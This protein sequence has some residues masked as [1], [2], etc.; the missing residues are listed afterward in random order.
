MV[1]EIAHLVCLSEGPIMSSRR[2]RPPRQVWLAL[3]TMILERDGFTCQ[4]CG[5]WRDL[6]IHH[7]RTRE[8]GGPDSPENLITL[9]RDCHTRLHQPRGVRVATVDTGDS[10]ARSAP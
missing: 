10:P 9:C 3:R 7:I 6:T 2:S 5:T 8:A 1:P 4:E